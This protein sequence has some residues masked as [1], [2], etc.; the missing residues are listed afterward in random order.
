MVNWSELHEDLLALIAK[1]L[2]LY[3]DF[4]TFGGVCSSWRSVA[5]KKNFNPSLQIPWLMLAEK[6]HSH[7]R[8]FFS[9]SKGMIHERMLPEAHGNR[10]F[11]SHGWLITLSVD[12]TINLV[13][14]LSRVRIPLPH[15]LTFKDHYTD[16]TPVEL[17]QICIFK[18]ILSA[19]P[20]WT[21]DYTVMVIYGPRVKLAFAKPGD[22]GWTTI[23][24]WSSSYADIIYYRERFYAVNFKGHIMVCDVEG[25]NPTEASVIARLPEEILGIPCKV[26]L[27]ESLGKL[28][29]V[30][31]ETTPPE[32]VNRG[33]EEEALLYQTMEF[34]VAELDVS[35]GKWVEVK[36]LG[37]RAMFLGHNSS[38]CVAVSDFPRCKANCIYFTDDHQEGYLNSRDGGG[39]DM[40]LFNLE[41][42]S[43]ELHY[44]GDSWSR[45]SPPM[46]VLPSL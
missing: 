33:T 37:D 21:S 28:L 40:G 27:V 46:W 5:V 44:K 45:L 25:P 16:Y 8:A 1:Q 12:L 20:S 34:R 36:N 15:Q 31:R 42:G 24:T 14:P 23:D 19:S 41:D 38:I 9:L 7:T 22:E 30:S 43:I 6:K 17:Q 13:N 2:I 11:S 29:V 4:V 39:K 18:A 32:F 35:N 26:Y 10:C 3:E